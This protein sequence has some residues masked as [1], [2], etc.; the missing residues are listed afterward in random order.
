MEAISI[1]QCIIDS[2]DVY[3][4]N[5]ETNSVSETICWF[6]RQQQYTICR[7]ATIAKGSCG[8]Q[9]VEKIRT[10]VLFHLRLVDHKLR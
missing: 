4:H 1:N 9:S 2:A 5:L 10:H 3:S 6:R 8:K 7:T